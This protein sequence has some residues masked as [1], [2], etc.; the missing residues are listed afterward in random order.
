[1]PARHDNRIRALFEC[2]RAAILAG[3]LDAARAL[4]AVY[5]AEP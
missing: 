1:M 5:A 3:D 4:L 2:V